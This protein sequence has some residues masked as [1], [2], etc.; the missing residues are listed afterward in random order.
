MRRPDW[1]RSSVGQVCLPDTLLQF[2]LVGQRQR[3]SCSKFI[4]SLAYSLKIAGETFVSF[5]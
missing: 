1:T 4:Y 3:D 2:V 5:R